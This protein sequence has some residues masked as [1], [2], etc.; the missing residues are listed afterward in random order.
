M[1]SDKVNCFSYN[2]TC[3]FWLVGGLEVWGQGGAGD[4]TKSG[5]RHTVHSYASSH[6]FPSRW[7]AW[8]SCHTPPWSSSKHPLPWQQEFQTFHRMCVGNMYVEGCGQSAPTFIR[9]SWKFSRGYYGIHQKRLSNLRQ[10]PYA[11]FTTAIR[12]EWNMM[13][14]QWPASDKNDNLSNPVSVSSGKNIGSLPRQV[15]RGGGE[16]LTI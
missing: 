8:L 15:S 2:T 6:G 5:S 9:Q 10:A 3:V 1:K 16:F 13:Q 4:V 11:V 14:M 7:M 12:M